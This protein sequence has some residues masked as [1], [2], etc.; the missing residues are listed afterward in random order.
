MIS[1]PIVQQKFDEIIKRSFHEVL[2][3][4][5]FKK[6]GNNFFLAGKNGYGPY[7]FIGKN[8]YNTKEQIDY[9]I[10]IGLYIPEYYKF[11][12]DKPKTLPAYPDF[13]DCA[14]RMEA[15]KLARSATWFIINPKTSVENKIKEM[16][17]LLEKYILPFFKKYSTKESVLEAINKKKL[18]PENH[19]AMIRTLAECGYK[20]YAQEIYTREIKENIKNQE[21]L[22]VLITLG[23]K[24]KLM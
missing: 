1:K 19:E 22:E 4:L 18:I 7:I 2:K 3:P 11:Y 24:Y 8:R 10:I 6:K 14:I 15:G 20:E 23:K 17:K 12:W 21:Y 5:G 9:T 16:K 13:G